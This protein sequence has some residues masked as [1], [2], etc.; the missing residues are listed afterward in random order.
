MSVFPI[1]TPLVN[2]NIILRAAPVAH[3]QIAISGLDHLRS[4]YSEPLRSLHRDVHR[5]N[6]GVAGFL[7]RTRHRL[8]DVFF[9]DGTAAQ[10][11]LADRHSGPPAAPMD[12]RQAHRPRP[13]LLCRAV[14]TRGVP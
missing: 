14:K 8:G 1:S 10:G 3:L 12:F 7:E 4:Q 6:R 9:V 5:F 13:W 11:V 2:S